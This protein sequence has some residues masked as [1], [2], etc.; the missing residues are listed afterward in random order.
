MNKIIVQNV[1][2]IYIIRILKIS[3]L[4]I[5][6]VLEDYE[7]EEG[8]QL[9]CNFSKKPGREELINEARVILCDEFPNLHREC[10]EAVCQKFFNLKGKVFVAVGDFR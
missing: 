1:R 10:F 6:I 4:S 8:I 5:R 7:I 3:H 9:Q 2:I